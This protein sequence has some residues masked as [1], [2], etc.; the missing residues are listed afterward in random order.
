MGCQ[1][2]KRTSLEFGQVVVTEEGMVLPVKK[3]PDSEKPYWCIDLSFE[4]QYVVIRCPMMLASC[5]MTFAYESNGHQDIATSTLDFHSIQDGWY[6]YALSYNWFPPK[7]VVEKTIQT[8]I[9]YIPSDVSIPD[10]EYTDENGDKL[11]YPDFTGYYFLFNQTE[12]QQYL[13]ALT[14][15]LR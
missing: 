12:S 6:V 3:T 10:R 2:E 5:Y 11:T 1:S 14:D 13:K 15:H 8:G 4:E 9:Y 7:S